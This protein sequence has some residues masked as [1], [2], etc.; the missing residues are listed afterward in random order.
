[1]HPDEVKFAKTI[2]EDLGRRDFTI[3]AMALKLEA[4]NVKH[5]TS[6]EDKCSMLHA[7]G[8]TVTDP[9]GGQADLKQKLI[10]A[11][12]KPE[13]RFQEDALRLMRA[14]RFGAE[15]GFE[16]EEK[17]AGAIAKLSDGLKHIAI[18]RI[19]DEFVKLIMAGANTNDTN[20]AR[21]TRT[22]F[23]IGAA[24]GTQILE[25]F[26]L[27]KHIIP[28][29]REGI[30]CGQNLHHIYTVWE[31]SLRALDY[32]AAQKYGLEIRLGALF[33]D[34]GKPRA[35]RGEGKHS[36]F[37]GHE[38]VGARMVKK[39][40]ERLKFSREVS[41]KVTHL[42][43]YHMFFYNTGE[44]SDAGVRRFLARVGVEN[45]DDL[46]KIR[47]ADRIGSG[48]PKAKPYKIRHL[49]FMIDKVRRDPITPKMLKVNG[50]DIM[51][52]LD[53]PPGPRVGWV[54]SALMDE[55]LEEPKRNTIKDLG[56]RIKEFGKFTDGELRELAKRGKEKIEEAE[57]GAEEEMKKRHHV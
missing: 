16:I 25:D 34:V 44:V 20:A 28:E 24:R 53:I 23:S 18:E 21:T 4:R 36:T 56:L 33:H 17:T 30:G 12:G 32:A 40:M 52:I 41:E 27:L 48:V 50:E 37:Y 9:Y 39:I 26:G 45:I 1:R 13:E 38:V 29:L 11:V 15:L 31:H 51:K 42:V 22:L 49:L 57:T 46:I 6:E 5:E 14:V 3:N 7:S 10:R 55:V 54:L 8:F 19:R 43:R 47:E 35:K 2:E